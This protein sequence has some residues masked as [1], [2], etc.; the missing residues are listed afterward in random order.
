MRRL[1]LLLLV[2]QLS[3]GQ[4]GTVI[5][6]HGNI[7]QTTSGSPSNLAIVRSY[8][9]TPTPANRLALGAWFN[10]NGAWYQLGA[11]GATGATGAKGTTGSTGATGAQGVTGA[12]GITGATGVTGATGNTGAVGATGATGPTGT[13]GSNG[14]TGATGSNG[15]TGSTGATGNTVLNA[16]TFSYGITGATSY[17]GSVAQAIKADT[18][19][20]G[21]NLAT[22]GYA[23]RGDVWVLLS[24][25]TASNSATVDFTGLSSDYD[26]YEV[27]IDNI[28]P[29]T[30]ST[31]FW[32]RVGT[33][34][35]P[36]YQTGSVY[37]YVLHFGYYNG[38]SVAGVAGAFSANQI[39]V[40]TANNVSNIS[41]LNVEVMIYDPSQTAT[42]HVMDI[43][44]RQVQTIT[45]T[46]TV[47]IGDMT[48]AYA[49]TTAVTAI[50]FQ[51]SSGD[52]STGTFKLYG[53]K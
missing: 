15:V 38:T 14:A 35:T 42:H 21:I 3:F 26:N 23:D 39:A 48:C 2:A 32:V 24:T 4:T 50:R 44:R 8:N 46:S 37:N 20:S 17:D 41:S 29:S 12:T 43:K 40:A 16:L 30:N 7:T 11:Q 6:T 27:V 45:S 18:S 10:D 31:D 53:I 22:Q 19:T 34:G 36:T 9:G 13:N 33:G 51:M 52:I 25:V 49:S 47:T 28:V 1:M 5:V